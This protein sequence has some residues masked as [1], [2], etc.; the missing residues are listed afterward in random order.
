MIDV[1]SGVVKHAY[2]RDAVMANIRTLVANARR[3]L[4]P[5]I[6]VRHSDQQMPKNS[7]DWQIVPEPSPAASE[8]VVDKNYGDA[9]EDTNL[10]SLLSAAGVGKLFVAG[11]QTDAC[12]RSTVHGAF[13]R[14]YDVTL[15][16]DAHTTGWFR[17]LDLAPFDGLIW[18][19]LEGV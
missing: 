1:Q 17:Q 3:D 5:V 18:P 6:W 19:H 13:V 8:Q 9:F 14:E 10:K 15:V 7:D 12:I 11:A 2:Q 16:S 4:I